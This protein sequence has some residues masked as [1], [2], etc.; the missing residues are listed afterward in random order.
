MIAL[1]P[2][3]NL[4]GTGQRGSMFEDLEILVK[5]EKSWQ[6]LEFF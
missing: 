6:D 3:K 4:E 1:P 5:L 2:P